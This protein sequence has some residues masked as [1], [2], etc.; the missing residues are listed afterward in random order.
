MAICFE[1]S[2]LAMASSSDVGAALYN[3]LCNEGDGAIWALD[4]VASAVLAVGA[5]VVVV[6]VAVKASRFLSDALKKG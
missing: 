1:P 5:S 4:T 2:M 6:Y 3:M